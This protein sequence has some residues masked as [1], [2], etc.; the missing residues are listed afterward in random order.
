MSDPRGTDQ[1][2]ARRHARILVRMAI[3]R[4]AIVLEDV[5]LYGPSV[6]VWHLRVDGNIDE[7]TAD[8]S[9][10]AL[11][12]FYD[13]FGQDRSRTSTIRWNGEMTTV[14]ANPE[15]VTPGTAWNSA[16]SGNQDPLPSS[17][18]ALIKWSTDSGG[19]SGKGK[20]FLAPMNKEACNG[21]G[22]ITAAT[23][24]R[25][26]DAATQLVSSSEQQNEWAFGVYSRQDSLLRDFTGSSMTNRFSVM[27]SRRI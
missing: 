5:S 23:V 20:T 7:S 11:K 16:A 2:C 27:T 8:S 9:M 4:I 24:T 26:R 18:A 6:N 13:A 14:D 22:R 10:A 1:R 19:R 3:Y 21:D 15:I 17:S 25:I 12:A